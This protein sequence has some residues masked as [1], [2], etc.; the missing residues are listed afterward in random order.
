MP[1]HIVIGIHR[2]VH[3]QPVSLEFSNTRKGLPYSQS[4]F[5]CAALHSEFTENIADLPDIN[6]GYIHT[7]VNVC[8]TCKDSR[9]CQKVERRGVNF[10]HVLRRRYKSWQLFQDHQSRSQ[11]TDSSSLQ[12]DVREHLS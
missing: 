2:W 6:L 5:R 4:K 3:S 10:G 11:N 8:L 7:A 9:Y 1:I 12:W